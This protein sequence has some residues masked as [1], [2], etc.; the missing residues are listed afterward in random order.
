MVTWPNAL[1]PVQTD[2]QRWKSVVE[3][4][5]APRWGCARVEGEGAVALPSPPSVNPSDQKASCEGP[6]ISQQH[7]AGN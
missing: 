4:A 6:T 2:H 3:H 7:Q 1:G 5:R